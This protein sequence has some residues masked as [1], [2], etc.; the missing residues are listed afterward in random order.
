VPHEIAACARDLGVDLI[1]MGRHRQ[2]RVDQMLAGS[3]TEKVVRQ[4]PCPVLVV[5]HPEHEFVL[6]DDAQT[7]A[8]R[9]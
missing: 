2:G 1:I 3:V 6:P 7:G 8:T 9:A 4:A 5:H